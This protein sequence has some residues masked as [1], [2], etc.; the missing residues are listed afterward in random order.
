MPQ[1]PKAKGS[2][3]SIAC[4]VAI[5]KIATGEINET[6]VKKSGR[7]KSGKAGGTARVEKIKRSKAARNYLKSCGSKMGEIVRG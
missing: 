2:A 5:A 7:V 4:A 6:P 1:A 3:D